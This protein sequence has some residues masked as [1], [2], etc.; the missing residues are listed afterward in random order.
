MARGADPKLPGPWGFPVGHFE[1]Y[2]GHIE[3]LRESGVDLLKPI[4]GGRPHAGQTY[5][6]HAVHGGRDNVIDYLVKLGADPAQKDANGR[7]AA[8]HVIEYKRIVMAAKLKAG[9]T[10]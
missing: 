10:Q 7:T 8:D 4:A 1:A 3:T 9:W 6:M 5:L 2:Y